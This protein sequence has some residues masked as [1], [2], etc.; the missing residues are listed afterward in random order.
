MKC[1][2]VNPSHGYSFWTRGELLAH[3]EGQ[4]SPP[5]CIYV[6]HIVV[7]NHWTGLVDCTGAGTGGLDRC[8]LMRPAGLHL[9]TKPLSFTDSSSRRRYSMNI[10]ITSLLQWLQLI[11]EGCTHLRFGVKSNQ[12]RRITLDCFNLRYKSIYVATCCTMNSEHVQRIVQNC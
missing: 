10:R 3:T 8:S 1:C 5:S 6:L 4:S 12:G 11:L 2:I 9:E 7:Y